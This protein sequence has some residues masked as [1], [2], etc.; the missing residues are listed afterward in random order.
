MA[1]RTSRPSVQRKSLKNGIIADHAVIDV[2]SQKPF[3]IFVSIFDNLPRRLYKRE[4]IAVES[5]PPKC[6]VH[7][8]IDDLYE[9]T[10]VSSNVSTIPI[11]EEP[12][13]RETEIDRHGKVKMDDEDVS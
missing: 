11:Y 8:F 1:Y 12:E 13:S 5:G 10:D 9:R 3:Y 2:L 7:S 4:K 6:I